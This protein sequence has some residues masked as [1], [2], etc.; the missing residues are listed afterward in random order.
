[1]NAFII[2]LLNDIKN[3][4]ILLIIR[5]IIFRVKNFKMENRLK[6][7]IFINVSLLLRKLN[8]VTFKE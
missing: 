1:M 8:K 4:K 6:R 7:K 5:Q 2:H 3:C